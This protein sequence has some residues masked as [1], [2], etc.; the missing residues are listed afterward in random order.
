MTL[1]LP[2]KSACTPADAPT[3]N[4]LLDSCIAYRSTATSTYQFYEEID[5]WLG[6]WGGSGYPI[7][8]GK[9]YNILF[10]QVLPPQKVDTFFKSEKEFGH[11]VQKEM[12]IR[13]QKQQRRLE[14][15][16]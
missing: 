14:N 3:V 5:A 15:N 2:P 12:E 10:S 7:G 8:Y 16:P 6:P 1:P 13:Q 9:K 4:A 11:F